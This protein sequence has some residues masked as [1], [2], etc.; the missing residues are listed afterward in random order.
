MMAVV[1]SQCVVDK[2]GERNLV[3]LMDVKS[4]PAACVVTFVVASRKAGLALAGQEHKTWLCSGT[5]R[6]MFALRCTP[7]PH[8]SQTMEAF[9][10]TRKQTN[11]LWHAI[12]SRT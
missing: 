4:L 8:A 12:M 3:E 2:T 6:K 1:E 9:L 11:S 10:A 5:W 7:S